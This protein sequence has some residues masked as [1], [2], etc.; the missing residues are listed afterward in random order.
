MGGLCLGH[1]FDQSISFPC[2]ISNHQ[3]P[4]SY[5]YFISRMDVA[6][7]SKCDDVSHITGYSGINMN[8]S[9]IHIMEEK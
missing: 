9:I 6:S 2:I 4:K 1:G 7:H 5:P 3:V 8:E